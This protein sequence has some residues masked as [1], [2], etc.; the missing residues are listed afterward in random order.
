MKKLA[1]SCSVACQGKPRA[2]TTRCSLLKF[3]QLSLQSM[4]GHFRRENGQLLFR[5]KLERAS[6]LMKCPALFTYHNP[7]STPRFMRSLRPNWCPE[8]VNCWWFK[9]NMLV[10]RSRFD[11]E[12]TKRTIVHKTVHLRLN[13]S[14]W[15]QFLSVWMLLKSRSWMVTTTTTTIT[16]QLR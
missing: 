13:L 16:R 11:L 4:F 3:V 8:C 5:L 1:M 12:E 7:T 10:E 15:A 2:L 9:Y 6:I 14:L